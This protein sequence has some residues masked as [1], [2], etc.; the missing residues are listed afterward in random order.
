MPAPDVSLV[1][2]ELAFRNHN[3]GDTELPD[4]PAFIQWAKRYLDKRG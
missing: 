2:G 3:G 1:D 4:W